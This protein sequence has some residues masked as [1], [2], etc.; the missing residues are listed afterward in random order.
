MDSTQWWSCL[1]GLSTRQVHRMPNQCLPADK[2]VVGNPLSQAWLQLL[3]NWLGPHTQGDLANMIFLLHQSNQGVHAGFHL[4]LD[5]AGMPLVWLWSDDRLMPQE[6]QPSCGLPVAVVFGF[7]TQC[8][9]PICPARA[10]EVAGQFGR[11]MHG[12]WSAI[13][14]ANKSRHSCKTSKYAQRRSVQGLW[15]HTELAPGW[16]R[17]L[18]PKKW[19]SVDSVFG[20]QSHVLQPSLL[21]EEAVVQQR[22]SQCRQEDQFDRAMPIWFLF[23]SL[24]IVHISPLSCS[25]S[26]VV[27]QLCGRLTMSQFLL[28]GSLLPMQ[29]HWRKTCGNNSCTKADWVRMFLVGG[30]NSCAEALNTNSRHFGAWGVTRSSGHEKSR[31][32]LIGQLL[33]NWSMTMSSKWSSCACGVTGSCAFIGAIRTRI[34][35]PEATSVTWTVWSGIVPMC[36]VQ[37]LPSQNGSISMTSMTSC[38]LASRGIEKAPW[39]MASLW[40]PSRRAVR[41]TA[42]RALEGDCSMRTW[43]A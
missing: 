22:A 38:R 15:W 1:T 10:Y 14:F 25:G 36:I 12:I 28:L 11:T 13:L 39:I 27:Q 16:H 17:R 37:D 31:L 43:Q 21:I 40:S 24:R 41:T 9:I 5:Q 7:V 3:H 26:S 29:T 20:W 4:P 30:L 33:S 18:T 2:H 32:V 35:V 6:I 34:L 23:P 19:P 42:A 8:C